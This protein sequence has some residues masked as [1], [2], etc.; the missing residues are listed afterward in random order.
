MD[1][2]NSKRY[3][4]ILRELSKKTQLIIVT[5]NRETMRVAGVLYGITMGDD[6]VSKLLS[7]KL[8]EAEVYTNR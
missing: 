5:H 7:L 3:A 2:A 4:E 1:E 8:E 6:G